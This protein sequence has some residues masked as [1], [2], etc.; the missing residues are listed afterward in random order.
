VEKN[1]INQ[2]NLLKTAFS[3]STLTDATSAGIALKWQVKYI[4]DKATAK[5]GCFRK[6]QMGGG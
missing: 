6:L 1:K 3:K 2:R 4:W 5:K